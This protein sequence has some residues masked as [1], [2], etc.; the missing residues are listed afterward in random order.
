MKKMI[1]CS[2]QFQITEH[3]AWKFNKCAGAVAVIT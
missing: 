1:F 2:Q 3:N